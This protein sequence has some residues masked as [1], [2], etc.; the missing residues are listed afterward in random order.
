MAKLHLL[1]DGAEA[2]EALEGVDAA[3][4]ALVAPAVHALA[5]G[6]VLVTHAAAHLAGSLRIFTIFF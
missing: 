4:G 1:V 3:A 5:A 6:A 2:R